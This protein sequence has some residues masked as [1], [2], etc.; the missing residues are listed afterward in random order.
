MLR[1]GAELR[2]LDILRNIDRGKFVLHYCVLSGLPGELDDEIRD[3]GGEV[4]CCGLGPSFA[5]R[6]RRLL[7]AQAYRVVHSHVHSSSGYF[8][9]L[10]YACA[11]PVRVAHFRSTSDGRRP[12]LRRRLQQA[13][14]ELE[15]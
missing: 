9:R 10:A 15:S 3:L 12:T 4:H 6:F 1:A 11:V 14:R 2:N 13:W 5:A 7:R 8:L